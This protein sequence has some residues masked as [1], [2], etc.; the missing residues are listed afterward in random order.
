MAQ[1]VTVPDAG[2]KEKLQ[3]GEDIMVKG[4]VCGHTWKLSGK[5]LE[6]LRAAA[7]KGDL[8]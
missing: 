5:D 4:S 2:L 8:S 7:A 6:S 3:S 1:S